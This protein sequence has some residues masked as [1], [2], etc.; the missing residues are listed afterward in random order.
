MLHHHPML[1]TIEATSA[2]NHKQMEV[3]WAFRH[4]QKNPL[5]LMMKELLRFDLYFSKRLF[6]LLGFKLL[7][8]QNLKKV[9]NLV[10][11]HAMMFFCK[12]SM[13]LKLHAY[14]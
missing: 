7:C 14:Y 10:L 6:P 11:G 12:L 4:L 9:A 1:L 5:P 3:R 2:I 8:W 13:T